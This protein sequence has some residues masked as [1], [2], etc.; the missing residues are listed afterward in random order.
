[1][2]NK[3]MIIVALVPQWLPCSHAVNHTNVKH[4]G[5]I[6]ANFFLITELIER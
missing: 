4:F 3:G 2:Y 6:H 5:Y 1:M